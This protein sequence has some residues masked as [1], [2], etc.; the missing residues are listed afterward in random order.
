LA[1][2]FQDLPG[3]T[4]M[5]AKKI[6]ILGPKKLP[7]SISGQVYAKAPAEVAVAREKI[8]VIVGKNRQF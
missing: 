6:Q 1:G 4:I 5:H 8:K 7:L 3:S 2:K